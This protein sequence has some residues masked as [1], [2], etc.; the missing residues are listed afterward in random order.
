MQALAKTP[1]A[2]GLQS[3]TFNDLDDV[4]SCHSVYIR[5]E[6]LYLVEAPLLFSLLHFPGTHEACGYFHSTRTKPSAGQIY[7]PPHFVGA[8]LIASAGSITRSLIDPVALRDEMHASTT[9]GSS[10]PPGLTLSTSSL[11]HTSTF[12]GT[13]ATLP[14]LAD[15]E[16]ISLTKDSQQDRFRND[17]TKRFLPA[18]NGGKGD[19]HPISSR[20]LTIGE[21]K[22]FSQAGHEQVNDAF[23]LGPGHALAMPSGPNITRKFSTSSRLARRAMSNHSRSR[24]PSP[25]AAALTSTSPQSTPLAPQRQAA[26]PL[27]RRS[28]SRRGSWQP[29]RKT[30][31]ELEEEY[32]DMDEDLPDDASLWNVPLSPRPPTGETINLS[33]LTTDLPLGTS[34]DKMCAMGPAYRNLGMAFPPASSMPSSRSPERTSPSVDGSKSNSPLRVRQSSVVSAEAAPDSYRLSKG[35]AKSWTVAM[36]ELS[37]DA[38]HLTEALESLADSS[39]SH[40]HTPNQKPHSNDLQRTRTSIDLPPLRTN[41]LMIDPLPISKEKERVLSRT[42]PS[43]LPPKS[44]KEEKRHLKEYQRMMEMSLQAGMIRHLNVIG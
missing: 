7:W 22:S 33:H 25:S 12:S 19:V 42:R 2:Q 30:A 39:T 34:V 27:I 18:M 40:H 17:R 32:D 5:D 3:F 4:P 10:S 37:K 1:A 38:Q 11:F 31:K 20:D 21:R 8:T 9:T 6:P 36:S 24:S 29:A 43:W 13:H 15:F 35:R 23:G 14:D 41:N 26:S 16:D 44:Q 28:T